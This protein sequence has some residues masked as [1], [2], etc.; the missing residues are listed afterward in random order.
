MKEATSLPQISKGT[1][2]LLKDKTSKTR[3]MMMT[4]GMFLQKDTSQQ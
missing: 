2:E 3:G 1:T 4:K